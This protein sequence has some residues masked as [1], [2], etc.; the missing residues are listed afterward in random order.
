MEK[1]KRYFFFHFLGSK[2]SIFDEKTETQKINTYRQKENWTI[3]TQNVH[4]T[5][6]N[7]SLREHFNKI[8]NYNQKEFGNLNH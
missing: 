7:K 8:K 4:D 2:N 6:I 1:K 3:D 5:K